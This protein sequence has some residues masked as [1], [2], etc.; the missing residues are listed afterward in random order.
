MRNPNA[1]YVARLLDSNKDLVELYEFYAPSTTTLIPANASKVFS[2]SEVTWSGTT[3]LQQA[4][5]RTDASGYITDRFD[6]VTVTLSNIDRTVGAWLSATNIKGY[7]LVIRRISRSVDTYSNVIFVGRCERPD[8]TSNVQVTILA[9][10]DLG[11]IDLSIPWG[12]VQAN[13]PLDFKGVECLAGQALGA[14]NAAYR[15]GQHQR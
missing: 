11:N 9:K 8:E 1:Q 10:Q 6:S 15:I 12:T 4:K 7:R 2:E 13:C 14:K 3:Y 5:G